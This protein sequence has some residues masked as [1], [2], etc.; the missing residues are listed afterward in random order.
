MSEGLPKD[1]KPH[2]LIERVTR[3]FPGRKAEETDAPASSPADSEQ[4]QAWLVAKL[5]QQLG[6]SA[7]EMNIREPLASYGLDS[8]TA[9]SLSGDL[10]NW[11]GRK[12]SPTLVW[13][14]PTI[15]AIADHLANN[16]DASP[17]S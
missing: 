16:S 6:I 14:Y 11:L 4:I 9:I 1:T 17:I 12:L 3:L 10:E 13:D 8:R 7:D 2:G 15:E 5:S